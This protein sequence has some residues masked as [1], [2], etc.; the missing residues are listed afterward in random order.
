GVD[1]EIR[2][3][4]NPDRLLALG[5]TAGD[6][7]AQLRVTNVD[8]AGGKSEIG[9]RQQTI[10]ALASA[11]TVERLAATPVTLPGGRKVRLDE[12]GTVTDSHEEPKNFARLN[13]LEVVGFNISRAKG[14]SDVVVAELVDAKVA[15]LSAKYPD[16][17]MR[18]VD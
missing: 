8:V 3:S 6:V 14:A 9:G 5:I 17:K 7:S 13:G 1:R 16:V 4:L 18:K 15:E 10:R 12:I 2:V 11:V